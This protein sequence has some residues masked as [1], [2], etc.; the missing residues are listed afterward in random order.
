MKKVLLGLAFIGLFSVACKKDYTCE[1]T[2]DGQTQTYDYPKVKKSDA[3][4]ACD[5]QET[6]LKNLDSGASC[7]LK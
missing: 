6:Q 2:Y 3:S 4:D 7:S 5:L 1:C